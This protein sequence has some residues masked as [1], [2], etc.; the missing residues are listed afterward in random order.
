MTLYIYLMRGRTRIGIY[1]VHVCTLIHAV[2]VGIEYCLILFCA[3]D[4]C[5]AFDDTRVALHRYWHVRNT[6]ASLASPDVIY[7]M[8]G[9]RHKEKNAAGISTTL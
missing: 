5:K 9:A 2:R 7:A 8:Q 1:N 6:G 4:P 3:T